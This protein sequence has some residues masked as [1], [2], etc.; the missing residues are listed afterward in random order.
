MTSHAG[1]YSGRHKRVFAHSGDHGMPCRLCATRPDRAD[2]RFFALLRRLFRHRQSP[3]GVSAG[4]RYDHERRLKI[5]FFTGYRYAVVS[6]SEL[7]VCAGW[8]AVAAA[9]TLILARAARS[10]GLSNASSRPS[11]TASL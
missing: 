6:S 10:Q 3:Q 8:R 4:Q 9:T 2:D 11:R 7:A 1:Q 5:R